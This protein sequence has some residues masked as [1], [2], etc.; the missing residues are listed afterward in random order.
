MSER[1][2]PYSPPGASVADPSAKPGSPVKAVLAGAAVDIVGS[3]VIGAILSVIYGASLA[4]S[5]A[6]VEEIAA[7][8]SEV[9]VDSWL[10]I[11][12]ILVGCAFSV[13]GGY[14]CARI[15][16]RSEYGLGCI[17][18]AISALF[19]LLFALGH[20]PLF[21]NLGLGLATFASVLLGA[22]LGYARNHAAGQGISPVAAGK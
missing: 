21:V 20:Y 1:H 3:L 11:S 15:A 6:S 18:G 12:G 5:G 19:G 8:S 22:R 2:N 9:P 13:L 10:F 4:V 16:K 17:V 7:A 14:V